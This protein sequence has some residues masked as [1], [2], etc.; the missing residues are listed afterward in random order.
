MELAKWRKKYLFLIFSN[1]N[2]ELELSYFDTF[3]VLYCP[4]LSLNFR[5]WA[6]IF[7][8]YLKNWWSHLK[9]WEK[10]KKNI[11]FRCKISLICTINN[12]CLWYLKLI[13]LLLENY[14]QKY[15]KLP[16]KHVQTRITNCLGMITTITPYDYINR[17]NCTI[18]PRGRKVENK[19]KLVFCLKFFTI[20]DILSEIQ[21]HL[22]TCT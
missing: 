1:A 16:T 4:L 21:N 10:K 7:C 14:C 2:K 18:W 11:G 3:K 12:L 17:K 8:E 5:E 6:N 15:S 9:E 20:Q 22:D 19:G 13:F